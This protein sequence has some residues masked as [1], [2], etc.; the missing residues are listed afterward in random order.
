[1]AAAPGASGSPDVTVD[2]AHSV[3]DFQIILRRGFEAQ[4]DL[5][6]ELMVQAQTHLAEM[7]QV[8]VELRLA[9]Q[10]V[11]QGQAQQVRAK[12]MELIDTKGMTP[13]VFNGFKT[14]PFK[15]W[16]N[17]RRRFGHCGASAG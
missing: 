4:N 6:N 17:R 10:A 3:D 7:A 13:S 14:E 11:Q 1:M 16:S 8:R 15:A 12:P 9:Q 2:N 5:R